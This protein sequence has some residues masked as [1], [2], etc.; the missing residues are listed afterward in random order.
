LNTVFAVAP[1]CMMTLE[2]E[3][4]SVGSSSKS[5]K[6]RLFDTAAVT[7]FGTRFFLEGLASRILARVRHGVD[8]GDLEPLCFNL[9]S[10]YD[11]TPMKVRHK[12]STEDDAQAAGP[13][14]LLQVEL[15]L[16]LSVR[17]LKNDTVQL[18]VVPH[19]ATPVTAIETSSAEAIHAVLVERLGLG[20]I[21]KALQDVFPVCA[22][23]STCDSAS[24][25]L[26]YEAFQSASS[27]RLQPR[28]ERPPQLSLRLR[29]ACDIHAISRVGTRSYA[30]ISFDISGLVAVCLTCRNFGGIKKLREAMQSVIVDSLEIIDGPPPAPSSAQAV[31]R[32]RILDVCL[33]SRTSRDRARRY[34]LQQLLHG[35][36]HSD[37]L[38]YYTSDKRATKQRFAKWLSKALLPEMSMLARNRWLTTTL[39][40]RQIALADGVHGL[41]RRAAERWVPPRR[42]KRAASSMPQEVDGHQR[43][44][45]CLHPVVTP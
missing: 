31:A 44:F 23:T 1:R 4:K 38:M 39:P 43:S 17:N 5:F 28:I 24:S 40:L 12:E 42:K 36:P 10:Q 34:K 16:S 8:D 13:T 41:F 27:N 14:K 35:D 6:R 15:C 45:T 22:H 32:D 3:A 11:D 26:R 19:I 37:Q 30:P 2:A 21:M 33:D 29:L 7:L 20:A 18:L 9:L 25:N